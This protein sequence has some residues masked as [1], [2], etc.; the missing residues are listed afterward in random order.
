MFHIAHPGIIV[1]LSL[2]LSFLVVVVRGRPVRG[3]AEL[4]QL[5]RQGDS[6]QRQPTDSATTTNTT[7]T[8]PAAGGG[9]DGRRLRKQQQRGVFALASDTIGTGIRQ[10]DQK[11]NQI[12]NLCTFN[13]TVCEKY[14]ETA[15]QGV[16]NLLGRIVDHRLIEQADAYNGWGGKGGG[17]LGVDLIS[18]IFSYYETIGDV[19]MLATMVCV[20]SGGRPR[21]N[22][23]K[24][25][26]NGTRNNSNSSNSNSNS[27]DGTG[28]QLHL[29]PAGKVELFDAYIRRYSDLLFGW[30]L[31]VKRAEL[32]K[33]LA[34][35]LQE[36]EVSNAD[37]GG[38]KE[39]MDHSRGA[40][41]GIGL[42]FTCPRC[43][44]SAEFGTNIC[45]S[46]QDFAF[47]C[48][49]CE[50]G[51]RGVFMVCDACG[52]GGH[53]NHVQH[54]F[55]KHSSCPSGCGCHC[56]FSSSSSNTAT[57]TTAAAAAAAIAGRGGTAPDS[58]KAGTGNNA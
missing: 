3:I 17:A 31:L 48:S 9:G 35:R 58:E 1:V 56:T 22:E 11:L 50:N 41:V 38:N 8:A 19:Q 52:H 12:K 39:Y 21:S 49:I 51:V 36:S 30:S 34:Q 2:F 7:T 54:W 27:S 16:W 25:G 5:R 6:G 18:N 45:Q 44:G 33:H 57:L 37:F 40:P 42:V 24:N 20:L 4:E 29:L 28:G 10:D 46:C 53:L 23:G 13:A 47:R 26:N 14:N 55:S 15:K 32:N 43:G